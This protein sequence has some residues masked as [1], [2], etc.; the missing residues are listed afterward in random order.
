[1]EVARACAECMLAGE[2]IA[3]DYS[4]L[5]RGDIAVGEVS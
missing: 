1:M 2:F 4:F 3:A 5:V